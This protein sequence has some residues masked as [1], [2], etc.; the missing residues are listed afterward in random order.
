M[1]SG[2]VRQSSAQIVTGNTIQASDFNNEYNAIQSAFSGS[3]GHDH[4]GGT[5]LGQKINLVTAT[6]GILPAANGGTG[7]ANTNTITLTGNVSLAGALT[8]SG[9]YGITLT[10]TN[11]TSITLPTSG[12][13]A[14][15][16]ANTFVGVQ[17]I[18][19]AGLPLI[20]NSTDSSAAKIQFQDNGTTRGYLRSNSSNCLE[21]YDNTGTSAIVVT[22]SGHHLQPTITNTQ[23]IGSTNA[24]FAQ[25][26]FGTIGPANTQQ[27]TL[28]AVTSDTIVLA[29]ATP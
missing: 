20:I 10:A 7:V 4:S 12:T 19:C 5:G 18:S 25:G 1:T 3:A 16:G 28:P 21:I 15:L 29:A 17:T 2:Y 9:A 26:Y 24:V 22:Q 13:L 14:I 23:N 8:T 27:H 11:T 6:T